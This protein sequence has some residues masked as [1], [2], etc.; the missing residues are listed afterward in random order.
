MFQRRFLNTLKHYSTMYCDT[1]KGRNHIWGKEWAMTM[2]VIFGIVHSLEFFVMFEKLPFMFSCIRQKGSNSIEPIERL[3]L[4]TG[5]DCNWDLLFVIGP[6]VQ[7]PLLPH[8]WWGT[9]IQFPKHCVL[10]QIRAMDYNGHSYWCTL[11]PETAELRRVGTSVCVVYDMLSSAFML[12]YQIK[13]TC[14]KM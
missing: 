1:E 13:A 9:K 3:V 2:T 5:R 7:E 12:L 10:K 6:T 8:T 11:S 14:C 4:I